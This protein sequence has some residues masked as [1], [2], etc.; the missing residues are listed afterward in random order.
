M[1]KKQRKKNKKKNIGILTQIIIAVDDKISKVFL[2][3]T[4]TFPNGRDK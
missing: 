1:N 3:N 2:A 4:E